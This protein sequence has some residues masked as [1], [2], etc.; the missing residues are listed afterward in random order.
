MAGQL[1]QLLAESDLDELREIIA[2]WKATAPDE[3]SRRMYDDLGARLVELKAALA[4]QPVQPT[5]A[6][7]ETA[8]TMM[9]K[10]AEQHGGR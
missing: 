7:L 1:A 3:R 9:L 2:R 5:R 6:E 8:L 10:L 4:E